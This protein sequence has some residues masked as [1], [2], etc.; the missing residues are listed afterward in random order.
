MGTVNV[1]SSPEERKIG[2]RGWSINFKFMMLILLA[3]VCFLAA[4]Y[5]IS[6]G[7]LRDFSLQTSEDVALTIL[8]GTDSRIRNLFEDYEA[9][10]RGLASTRAVKTA[11]PGQMRDLF[12]ST[13]MAWKRYLRA[14]YLGTADGRM[15]EWGHGK[16]FT[17]NTPSFPPGYDPRARP[18]YASALK[19][20]GFGISPPYQFASVDA[21][22]I[23]CVLQVKDDEGNFIGVIGMDILLENLQLIL[24]DLEIPKNGRAIILGEGGEVIAGGLE[25]AHG[26]QLPLKRFEL[27][28][29]AARL[30]A[31]TGRF[32]M[33]IEGQETLFYFRKSRPAG[34]FLLV[35]IPYDSIMLP[36]RE[37][38]ALITVMEALLMGM[39]MMALS[40]ISNGLISSPL[41]SIVSVINRIEGG[42]RTARVRI[43][44]S[45]EFALLGRELN[46][47]VDT[48]EEYSSSL[49]SKVKERTEKLRALQKENTRL[50]V[51]E[52][53]KRIYRDMHD[54][55][56]AKLT[57]IFFCNSVA[58]SA[59]E[60]EPGKLTELFDG[61]E[62]NCLD[63]VRNLK[64]IIGGM[65]EG[66]PEGGDYLVNLA[67]GIRR[68]LSHNRIRF[69]CRVNP[70]GLDE[71]LDAESKR[72]LTK[73]FDELVSNAL[74]HSGADR[75][76]LSFVQE[77]DRLRARFRDNGSGFDPRAALARGSG[78]TN[79]DFRIVRLG[80]E[81][82]IRSGPGKGTEFLIR[83]PMERAR[84]E[85]EA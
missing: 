17:D 57:N 21:L 39:L 15:Y 80:G 59:A 48:V 42:E 50:R 82:E 29:L 68:R 27:P 53:R 63:A 51:T 45:D 3:T 71:A 55:L 75:V 78:L 33:N 84:A 47:L 56:G 69:G 20:E 19:A 1:P 32:T 25:G 81:L 61:I 77:G 38:L 26:K 76:S 2:K 67:A 6:F 8:D 34:W 35:G 41:H 40:V 12:V 13:V 7:M 49:E 4:I 9:L 22:G 79:I 64:E 16:E 85:E 52:E 18:W 11:D 58:R 36:V 44:S 31:D 54:S 72:E 30:S 65:R 62:T 83:I 46:K 70:R 24:D 5:L 10:A 74:K 37:L 23:T 14:I 66:V 73:I 28:D 60:L 43:S